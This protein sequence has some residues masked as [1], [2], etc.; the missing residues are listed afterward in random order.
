[1]RTAL[2]CWVTTPRFLHTSTPL[3]LHCLSHGRPSAKS[4][5]APT[6]ISACSSAVRVSVSPSR[7]RFCL[8]PNTLAVFISLVCACAFASKGD[9]ETNCE[10]TYSTEMALRTIKK[11]APATGVS[12]RSPCCKSMYLNS[13]SLASVACLSQCYTAFGLFEEFLYS[14]SFCE[15]AYSCLYPIRDHIVHQ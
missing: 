10:T 12:T 8:F 5:I 3:V 2:A 9:V 1:M 7:S 4:T 13:L 6:T 14:L 15:P 11:I